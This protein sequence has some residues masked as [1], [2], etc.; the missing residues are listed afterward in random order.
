[1]SKIAGLFK[2]SQDKFVPVIRYYKLV[3]YIDYSIDYI[4]LKLYLIF[5]KM[6]TVQAVIYETNNAYYLQVETYLLEK[7]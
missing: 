3:P 4:L 2:L 1:M 6:E 5:K 7:R